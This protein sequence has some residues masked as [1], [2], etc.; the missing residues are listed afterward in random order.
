MVALAGS[1]DYRATALF[2]VTSGVQSP[3]QTLLDILWRGRRAG[4]VSDRWQVK[5]FD[6]G[7]L[8]IELICRSTSEA[9]TQIN[10]VKDAFAMQLRGEADLAR[11]KPNDA[12][13]T[14]GARID[15]LQ[16]ALLQARHAID[17]EPIKAVKADPTEVRHQLHAVLAGK[18]DSYHELR[19]I[20]KNLLTRL[21]QLE[22]TPLPAKGWIDPQARQVALD[23]RD[24]LTQELR[25]LAT[26]LAVIQGQLAD[27]WQQASPRL[28]ELVDAAGKLGQITAGGASPHGDDAQGAAMDQIRGRSAQLSRRIESFARRWTEVF[29]SVVRR[30][31]VPLASRELE[32]QARLA[33]LLAEF[34]FHA[35]KLLDLMRES[36]HNLRDQT[37]HAARNHRTQ[38]QTLRACHRLEAEFARFEFVASDIIPR[39]NFRLDAAMRSARGLRF[40]VGL[41][42]SAIDEG[43]ATEALEQVKTQRRTERHGLQAEIQSVEDDVEHAVDEILDAQTELLAI[44]P[45][46][47]KAIRLQ[48]SLDGARRQA[49]TLEKWLAEDRK[50]LAALKTQREIQPE[51]EWVRL[52][53]H[54]VD[55]IPIDLSAHI[56][57]GVLAATIVMLGALL[58]QQRRL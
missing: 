24:D 14:A 4:V 46:T 7:K 16:A 15:R 29:T 48:Y 50:N 45:E 36:T 42:V 27:V 10:H 12:E 5:A 2:Q 33:D 58:F 44:I 41:E 28:D 11:L 39:N 8:G 23:A 30:P 51:G 56:L 25:Q 47:E 9:E 54:S 32:A 13:V 35:G 3:R 20:K 31:V 37:Q 17:D 53:S 55:A 18:I 6:D 22:A 21:D 1:F 57:W 40:R 38:S 52:V 49:A 26:Q 43:L 34:T 19:S